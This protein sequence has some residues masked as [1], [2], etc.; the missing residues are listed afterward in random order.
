MLHYITKKKK[1]QYNEKNTMRRKNNTLKR[2]DK[3]RRT[4]STGMI[5]LNILKQTSIKEH[6]VIQNNI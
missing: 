5:K 2:N 3:T 1:T 4:M 6:I